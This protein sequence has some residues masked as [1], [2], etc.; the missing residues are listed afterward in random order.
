MVVDDDE[1]RSLA[2]ECDLT[3]DMVADDAGWVILSARRD[4]R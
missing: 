2:L 3:I 1:L 4:A